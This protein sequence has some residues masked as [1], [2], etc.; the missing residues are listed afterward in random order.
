[1]ALAQNSRKEA[2]TREMTGGE[3]EA[4]YLLGIDRWF[5]KLAPL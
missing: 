4:E 2:R 1:M 5:G 3:A